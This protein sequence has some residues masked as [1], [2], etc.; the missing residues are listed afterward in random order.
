M[1]S[2]KKLGWFLLSSASLAAMGAMSPA[3]AQEAEVSD[4]IVV[5]AT[6]RSAAIQ[7]VPIAVQAIG[8]ETLEQGGVRSLLD[9]RQL[10]PSMRIGTG[11]S[12]T[13]GAAVSIR[14]I[15][16]GSDNPGFEAAVGVFIDGVYRARTGTALADLPETERVEILRG[17]QGTLFGKNTSAGAISVITAG[18]DF[19]PGMW[20]E[21]TVGDLNAIGTR[22]GANIPLVEDTV[23]FRIDGALRARDGFITDTISGNLINDINRWSGRAQLLWDISPDASLRIIADSSETDE[24]CCAA[25]TIGNIAGPI[26][27]VAV[28]NG[29]QAGS[30]LSSSAEL[31]RTT[32]SAGRNYGESAEDS[33]V[34]AQLDWDLGFANL[35]SITSY[36]DW[37]AVRNQ[38]IDFSAMDRSFREGLE[39]GVSATTQEI[40]LQGEAGPV[41]WLVGGFYS[42]E[43]VSQ[44]DR[45]RHGAQAARYLDTLAFGAAGFDIFGT[46]LGPTLTN[47]VFWR[48]C[49]GM[50]ATQNPLAPGAA[51]ILTQL[52]NCQAASGL[53]DDL[54]VIGAAGLT[55]AGQQADQWNVDTTSYSLF[56]H[57]EIS[58]GENMVLTLG[59]RMNHEEKDL[60]ANLLA[61]Q[62]VCD[63]IRGNILQVGA[64]AGWTPDPTIVAGPLLTIR[65]QMLALQAQ[66]PAVYLLG[67]NPAVNNL[68]NG[69]Y[70]TSVSDDAVSGVASLAY[71][72]SDDVMLF[73]T[74]SRGYKSGGFN[75]DRSG[76]SPVLPTTLTPASVNSLGFAPETTDSY[77]VGFKSTLLGGSTDFN[78]TLFYEQIHDFQSN[79]FNGFN[80]I[81]RNVPET[82]SRGVELELLSRPMDHLTLTGGVTYNEAFYDSTVEFVTGDPLNTIF[83]GDPL[84]QAPEWTVTGSVN[85][86]VPVGESMLVNFFGSGRWVSDYRLQTLNRNPITDQEGFAIFDARVGI[87]SESGSWGLDLFVQNATDEYYNV[88]AFAVPEQS[89]SGTG[90]FAAFPNQPRTY[91]VTLRARY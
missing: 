41:N 76:F 72:L 36:R 7:D 54:R 48:T 57:D 4:E 9:L 56:T 13:S 91:G 23:A 45:I 65:N 1:S 68:Q 89:L 83:A 5:T 26:P 61:T 38:D 75:I 32:V 24:N 63:A 53:A 21:G 58:L 40:R 10:V 64:I 59:A 28:V 46:L 29:T 67:C 73:G 79:N 50:A 69:A 30:I 12:T 33:G 27:F 14:G 90:R 31:R 16:T 2:K 18:P 85:Y 55:G 37:N 71:H 86:G 39:V 19:S 20:M 70:A 47:S 51:A 15:G 52:A 81:T 78:V 82:I 88:G 87:G 17:P 84:T 77:E 66:I 60:T 6:G 8:T 74:Y 22:F 80:F 35:T 42:D 62:P 43:T 25:V 44:T 3:V 11:Q 34:S 49:A